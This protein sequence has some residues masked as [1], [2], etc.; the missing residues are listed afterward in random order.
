MDQLTTQ[1]SNPKSYRDPRKQRLY[2]K[3]IDTPDAWAEHLK[4]TIPECVYYLNDCIESRTGGDGAIREPNEYGQMVYG[5]VVAPAGDLMCS[6]PPEMRALNMMCYIGHEGTYTP[7]HREMCASLGHNIMVEASQDG[8]GEK[9]GSS[10]W[11]MTETK[12]REVVSEYFLSMLGHDIEVEK[13]FAQTNAWKKAPFNVWVVEQKVG[14]LILIPPLAPHQVWNRG[15]R[16][17]KAAWNRTTVDTLELALHEALPR[18]R[19]VCRDEQYKCKAIIYYTLCNYYELL[20]RD[21]I[22]PKMWKYGRIKQLLDDFRR[23]FNLYQEVLVSEIFSPKLPEE[24]DVE[25]LPFDSNVTCS[26]CRG[27]IFNRFLTCKS[28]ILYGSDGEEDTY[29]V[30]MDCYAMGRSCACISN[31]KWVEQWEWKTLVD[32]Y[33][34]WRGIVVQAD[35]FFDTYRSPQPLDVARKRYG[36]KPIAEVCQEQLKIRPWVDVTKP[37][38]PTPDLSESEPEVDD[39]GRIKKKKGKKNKNGKFVKGRVDKS[40]YKTHPCHICC[41]HDHDWKLVFCTT[42]TRAYCYGTLWR[43][44]DMMPQT[45]MEDKEWQCPKCLKICSCGKCRKDPAQKPY[46]PKGT[47]LGHDTRK[48]ADYRSVESLVDFSKTNLIWLRDEN[49]NNP[50]ESGRMKALKEK[51]EAEKAKV[52]TVEPSYLEDGAQDDLFGASNGHHM[53]DID[54]EL[55]DQTLSNT[56]ANGGSQYQTLYAPPALNNGDHTAENGV[57]DPANNWMETQFDIDDNGYAYNN[58]SASYPSGLLGTT[59]VAPMLGGDALEQTYP[60]PSHM[61]A[62]M[63]GSGYYTQG[64]GIDRILYDA[65]NPNES[66][67]ASQPLMPEYNP[68]MAMSDLLDPAIEPESGK[69]RK[70]KGDDGYISEEDLEFFTSKKQRKEAKARKVQ[71]RV[72]GDVFVTEEVPVYKPPRRSVGKPQTYMDLGEAAVPIEEDEV[73]GPPTNHKKT[74]KPD[75]IDSDLDLATQ[76]MTHLKKPR[77]RGRP[78]KS[79]GAESASPASAPNTI[80][81]PR[82]SAWLARKEAAE[83]GEDYAEEVEEA[84][85]KRTRKPRISVGT[86][87]AIDISS[88]SDNDD[89]EVE[90]NDHNDYDSLFDEP[91]AQENGANQKLEWRPSEQ[92]PSVQVAERRNSSASYQEPSTAKSK[93]SIVETNGDDQEAPASVPKRGRG[94]PPKKKPAMDELSSPSPPPPPARVVVELPKMLSLKEKLALKGKS[95]KIVSKKS[96]AS[97]TTNRPTTVLKPI[98]KKTSMLSIAT[99]AGRNSVDDD[100]RTGS[101]G[102]SRSITPAASKPAP[103]K[104]TV[105]LP[106]RIGR[107]TVV[108]LVSP[109]DDEESEEARRETEESSADDSSSDDEDIPAVVVAPKLTAI[110]GGGVNLRGRGILSGMRGRGRGRPPAVRN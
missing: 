38:E 7:A 92:D 2:L 60:D 32:N 48:V 85:V 14:D 58:S 105:S 44:F 16:T 93:S 31:L 69:K 25:F 88:G 80:K 43:A 78:K 4:N 39:E 90:V 96:Q 104:S 75:G 83:N 54:P 47:L 61:G 91:V 66:E 89:D 37:K 108:R 100:Y 33:E 64:N 26:Y 15:T 94:R 106:Q 46:T 98:L 87:K 102:S 5:K 77:G 62:R 8:K 110:R 74:E 81:T 20:Q 84:S 13:H 1:L 9:A 49:S 36:K 27:N 23:L 45:V 65:P 72:T 50:Q 40:K 101:S 28:C 35:G 22:E 71:E 52:D 99:P 79:I 95:A 17:M 42:C 34:R 11:F 6:L 76:G 53:D 21:T 68:N 30:C 57:E 12:E 107:P 29:D 103:A 73:E 97:P 56:E 82:K 18:A 41:H 86:T 63:M 59:P 10:I 3:D 67:E 109:S 70:R 51:A 55:R 24:E 19:M